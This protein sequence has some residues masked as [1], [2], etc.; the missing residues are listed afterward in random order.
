[1][2]LEF[3]D[4]EADEVDDLDLQTKIFNSK[5]KWWI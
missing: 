5:K 4:D 3:D 1:M 2:Q